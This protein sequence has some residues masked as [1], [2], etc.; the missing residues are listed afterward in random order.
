MSADI[1]VIKSYVWHGDDCYFVSTIDRDNSAAASYGSRYAETLVWAY[2]WEK[3]ERLSGVMWHGE[4][5]G[6]GSI[7]GHLITCQR[8]HDT[9]N[10]DKAEEA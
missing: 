4:S 6:E 1:R 9:G 3:N 10:P 8:I 7:R 5:A 2:D